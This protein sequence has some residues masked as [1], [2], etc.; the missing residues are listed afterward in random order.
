M[1]GLK[2]HQVS[3]FASDFVCASVCVCVCVSP[4]F[5][6]IFVSGIWVG[7][8]PLDLELRV[9]PRVASVGKVSWQQV[10]LESAATVPRG[11]PS[12]GRLE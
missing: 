4:L 7:C 8:L 3:V 5:L 1:F 9:L 10:G 12:L 2:L 11:G 6:V